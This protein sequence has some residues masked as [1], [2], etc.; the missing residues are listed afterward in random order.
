M[1]ASLLASGPARI[2]FYRDTR[3]KNRRDGDAGMKHL[4]AV[5]I[6]IDGVLHVGLTPVPG[7]A[8]ALRRLRRAGPKVAFLTNASR[9]PRGRLVAGLRAM[10]FEIAD[11]EVRTAVLAARALIEQRGL[12]PFLFVHPDLRP[13]W[14]GISCDEPNAVVIGDAAE[15]FKYP[16]LNAAFRVLMRDPNVPLIAMGANRYY[17]AADGLNLDMGAFV[18]ALEYASRRKAEF[19]GKPSAKFFEEALSAMGIEAE[20]A[21]M[22][23][24]D[25]ENDIGAAQKVG[26]RGVL[27][28]TG[29]F[30]TK[31][32]SDSQVHPHAIVDDFPAAVALL[33]QGLE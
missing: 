30:R 27:V 12:R 22:I 3:F 13:D 17:Q 6:D 8:E 5:L 24:D 29:K 16:A 15:T 9:V 32:E 33:L 18:A 26:L 28:R 21:V 1:P 25:L 10:G 14:E 23:G 31:D 19:T 2:P 11:G 20:H 4:Q 7:A